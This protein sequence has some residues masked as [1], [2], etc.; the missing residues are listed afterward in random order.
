[1]KILHVITSINRGG[2]ENHLIELAG[3]QKEAGHMVA[4]AYLKGNHYWKEKFYS[5]GV[6]TFDLGLNFYGDIQPLY[7]LWKTFN[8]FKPDFV[9]VHLPPA[10]LYTW[11]FLLISR[12]RL[13]LL[14]SKHNDEPF[15]RGLFAGFLAT[16]VAKRAYH[17]IAISYAVKNF[18]CYQ[19]SIVPEDKTSIVYYGINTMPYQNVLRSKVNEL[20]LLWGVENHELLFGVVARFVP[21]KSLNTLLDGFSYFL[22]RANIK[23][24][25]VLVGEGPLHQNLED[26][27]KKLK[28]SDRVIFSGFRED[29]PIVMNCLDVFVLT[30]I[31]EGFGLVLLE[32]MAASRPIV[33]S[34]VSAIPEIVEHEK[35]GLLFPTRDTE[36]L[37]HCLLKLQ[38][39]ELRNM[40]GYEGFHRSQRFFSLNTMLNE[41]KTIM[42][43]SIND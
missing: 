34:R 33:A 18:L 6:L 10:E 32:A 12:S 2:A 36:A 3:F 21:Q 27:A 14:I 31:Y 7:R 23:S 19:N 41:T 25:L 1:M 22:C 15:Y 39:S 17:I 40:Y 29:I 13:P 38:D 43:F 5:D 30:S 11:F 4:V 35:T 42:K 26:Q 20:R 9:H 16:C 24:K 28:I 8:Q 37:G